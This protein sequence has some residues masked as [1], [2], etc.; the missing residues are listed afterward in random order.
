[1][2]TQARTV[3]HSGTTAAGLQSRCRAL[4]VRQ[5]RLESL[6]RL[7]QMKEKNIAVRVEWETWQQLERVRALNEA[8]RGEKV[9]LSEIVRHALEKYTRG[10]N[11]H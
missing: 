11:E 1:M 6:E 9:S 7:Q 8:M 3:T 10:I 2:Q 5:R 4:S